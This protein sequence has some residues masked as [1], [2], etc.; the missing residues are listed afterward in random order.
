MADWIWLLKR[1][2]PMTGALI[3]AMFLSLLDMLSLLAIT[4]VQKW[5]I[6]D[7][8]VGAMYERL[9]EYVLI[10]LVLIIVYNGIHLLS[11]MQNRAILYRL[12]QKLTLEMMNHIYR[13]K[14]SNY[15]NERIGGMA[16]RITGDIAEASG[17]VSHFIPGGITSIVQ[18]I[19]LAIFIGLAH[20]MLLL[21]ICTLSLVLVWS[22]KRFGS[23]MKEVGK[24]VRDAKADVLVHIEEGVASTREVVAFH[25]Q[26][27]EQEKYN[28]SFKRYFG[29][30]MQ[31][32]K[33]QNMQLAGS[34][35]FRWGMSLI[36]I[37]YGAI[38]AINGQISIGTFVV[39]YQFSSQLLAGIQGIYSFFMNA[40]TNAGAITRVREFLY[41]AEPEGKVRLSED[42]R[43][44]RFD[45]VGFRYSE[46]SE[47]VLDGLHLT[48]PVGKKVALVGSSGG[49]KST[50]A[51]LLERFYE[52]TQGKITVNRL[53]LQDIVISDWRGK[54][55]LV[56]QEPYF[57][58]DTIRNNLLM[59]RNG[60]TDTD[61]ADACQA[62]EIHSMITDF[63]E[64]YDTLLGERGIT[65]S[66]GQ[67]QRLAIARAL[68]GNP[69][70][71]ILDEAT[72]A[73]DQ[74]TER[75]VQRNLDQ[76]REGKT[77]IIIA[78]RLSTVKNADVI[79]VIDSGKLV[80]Q[81]THEQLMQ[82]ES[83]YRHFVQAKASNI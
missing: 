48:I 29:K 3:V 73:L 66:G 18:V 62:A 10:F 83:R 21:V 5:L 27:W 79:C 60:M 32:V 23:R 77:T 45:N 37:A 39:V 4:G 80:E 41:G 67:R 75:H 52:P 72:S 12:Q 42:I 26:A 11:H 38:L 57:F 33:F 70:I 17:F 7:V 82:S 76:L 16:Q 74:E 28:R 50:V 34:E 24:E 59:G 63:P 31:E 35:S 47:L 68:L 36:V 6:D 53:A 54:V 51:Q 78:H 13:M 22:A 61:I 65:L 49:G 43:E 25:R 71:L 46:G 8:F 56:P 69:D 30:V 1:I 44:I 20:P 14:T 81:G 19:V 58:P 64:G 9:I 15:H 55:I 40:S 2:R